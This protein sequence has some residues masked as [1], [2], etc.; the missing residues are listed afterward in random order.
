MS[1]TG[2]SPALL[3]AIADKLSDMAASAED[4]GVA[5]TSDPQI[6]SE[7]HVQLQKI[8]VFCQTLAQLS[9]I[10]VAEAPEAAVDQVCLHRLRSELLASP[11]DVAA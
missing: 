11:N 3:K 8:D 6:V 4:L 7:H 10:L 1:E 9:D 2:H 5:L